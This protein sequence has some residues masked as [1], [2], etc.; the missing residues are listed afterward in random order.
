M[1]LSLFFSYIPTLYNILVHTQHSMHGLDRDAGMVAN[2]GLPYSS[3][4]C[5]QL[6][7]AAPLYLALLMA[8]NINTEFPVGSIL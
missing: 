3:P 5:Y 1:Y 2:L 8:V 4:T 6:S 7:Y